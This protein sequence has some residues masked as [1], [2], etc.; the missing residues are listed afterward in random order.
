MNKKLV[1]WGA[2]LVF[3][4]AGV[5]GSYKFINIDNQDMTIEQAAPTLPL[6]SMVIQSEPF[7][8]LRGFTADMDVKDVARYVNP[9]DE[10]RQIKGQI[11]TLGTDVQ[12]ASYEVRNNDGSRLIE[13]GELRW[14][15][16]SAGILD[17][18]MKLK[19]LI[20]TGEEYILVLTLQTEA[21]PE[22]NY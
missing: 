2:F 18:E 6:V 13:A 12:K 4:L 3:F 5:V 11:E 19:D 9:I 22:I 15:E 16:K 20:A 17:F 14:Q 21:C 1:M 7:N 8:T 10:D